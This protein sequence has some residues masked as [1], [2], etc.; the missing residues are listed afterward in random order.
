MRNPSAKAWLAEIDEKQ[1][2]TDEA[3][4]IKQMKMARNTLKVAWIA[5][6][7]A[8]VGIFDWYPYLAVSTALAAPSQLR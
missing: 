5:A 3:L 8:I 1:R 7:A 6:G 2:K 4:Q